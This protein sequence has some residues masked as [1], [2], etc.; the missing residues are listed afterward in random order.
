MDTI[1]FSFLQDSFYTRYRYLYVET[2]SHRLARKHISYKDFPNGMQMP[3]CRH[4]W[5]KPRYASALSSPL[6]LTVTA[7]WQKEAQSVLLYYLQ[8]G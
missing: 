6:Q 5:A 7:F 3:E 1:I 8:P 4:A 2:I